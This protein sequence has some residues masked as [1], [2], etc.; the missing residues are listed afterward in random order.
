MCSGGAGNISQRMLAGTDTPS[1][2]SSQ[3]VDSHRRSMPQAAPPRPEEDDGCI[4]FL[5]N[6]PVRC[7]EEEVMSTLSELG[8]GGS[9]SSVSLP[10]RPARPGRAH[11]NRGYGFAYFHSRHE[12]QA[13]LGGMVNG[14][15]VN[16]RSSSKVVLVEPTRDFKPREGP[17]SDAMGAKTATR[18]VSAQRPN[19]ASSLAS[20][21]WIRL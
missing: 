3:Q 14:F 11:H 18:S 17:T 5:R 19:D 6:L 1:L 4:L 8:W 21:H 15:R 16:T 12:A 7:T 20:G 10:L 9:I 2:P 13:F